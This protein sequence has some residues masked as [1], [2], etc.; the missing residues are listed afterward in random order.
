VREGRHAGVPPEQL[1]SQLEAPSSSRQLARRRFA[2]NL[3]TA[4]SA[5]PSASSPQTSHVKQ[6]RTAERAPEP[7]ANDL[8]SHLTHLLKTPPYP[9]CPICYSAVHPM[10]PTWSCSSDGLD[11]D[12]MDCCWTTFHMKCI[13]AWA[14]KSE[15]ICSVL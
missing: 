10:Q 14:S 7:E 15:W 4:G 5:N 12:G 11:S 9:D 1:Q 3:T 13:R 2:G 6:A 8:T